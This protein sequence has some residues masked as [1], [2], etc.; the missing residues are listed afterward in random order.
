M[1]QCPKCEWVPRGNEQWLCTC[2]HRWD[3]F[4]TRGKCP[5][6]GAQW[7]DTGCLRCHEASPHEEWYS[8]PPAPA[9]SDAELRHVGPPVVTFHSSLD[10]RALGEQYRLVIENALAGDR[11]GLWFVAV[12]PYEDRILIA[13]TRPTG[14]TVEGSFR[15]G[16]RA[17]ARINEEWVVEGLESPTEAGAVLRELFQVR[18]QRRLGVELYKQHLH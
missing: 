17:A 14:T 9:A 4:T 6:C 1:I 7:A 10:D 13:L 3:M 15:G 2:G 12:R 5:G 18:A 11:G 16:V 8:D